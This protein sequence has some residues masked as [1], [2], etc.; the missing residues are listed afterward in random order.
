MFLVCHS[1]ELV[2]RAYEAVLREAEK[3]RKFAAHVAQAA[4]RV[5]ALKRRSTALGQF[6]REPKQR[7][8]TRLRQI[9]QEF[10]EVISDNGL[11]D[12]FTGFKVARP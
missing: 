3:D 9:V 6:A 1:E 7:V 12:R 5:L 10:T 4:K 11:G 2:Y 8:I